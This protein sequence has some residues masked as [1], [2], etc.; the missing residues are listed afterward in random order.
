MSVNYGSASRTKEIDTATS[1]VNEL[2]AAPTDGYI[3]IDHINILPTSAVT[4]QFRSGSTDI[5]GPYPLDAKQP[6]TLENACHKNE[7]I[8]RCARNEAFNMNLSGAVQV[9]GYVDFRVVGS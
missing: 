1:G 3:V 7:G 4:V 5:A 2:I 8:M 6:I 9:G